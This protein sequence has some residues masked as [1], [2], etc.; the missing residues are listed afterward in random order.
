[1]REYWVYTIF[2][3]TKAETVFFVFL[4]SS[5]KNYVTDLYTQVA[6]KLGHNSVAAARSFAIFAALCAQLFAPFIELYA[7]QGLSQIAKNARK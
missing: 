3:L 2:D 5:H 4:A 1:M 7:N 6:R